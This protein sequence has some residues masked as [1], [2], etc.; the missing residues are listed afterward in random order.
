ML[1]LIIYNKYINIYIHIYTIPL[2]HFV[3]DSNNYSTSQISI[4][5]QI[6]LFY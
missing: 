5:T 1:S 4:G 3:V 2:F 6:Q